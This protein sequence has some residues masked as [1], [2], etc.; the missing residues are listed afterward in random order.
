MFRII[1]WFFYG[2]ICV[3]L[4]QIAQTMDSNQE[5]INGATLRLSNDIEESTRNII[6]QGQK[7]IQDIQQNLADSVKQA[8]KQYINEIIK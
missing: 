8:S 6:K 4:W 3:L 1:K 7:N 5:Q 2:F